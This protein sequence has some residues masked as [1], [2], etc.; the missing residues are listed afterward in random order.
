MDTRVIFLA[1]SNLRVSIFMQWVGTYLTGQW[2]SVLIGFSLATIRSRRRPI[3]A[4]RAIFIQGVQTGESRQQN[5]A[6]QRGRRRCAGRRMQETP[7]G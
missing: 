4:A 6:Q 3:I 2:R 7:R 1:Q 5:L